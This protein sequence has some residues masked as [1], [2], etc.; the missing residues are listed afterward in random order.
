VQ[1][2]GRE[3]YPPATSLKYGR[4]SAR[5]AAFAMSTGRIR[6]GLGTFDSELSPKGSLAKTNH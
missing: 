3:I 5:E 4:E 1:R 6:A 2:G